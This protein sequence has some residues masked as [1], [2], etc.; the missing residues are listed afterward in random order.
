[1]MTAHQEERLWTQGGT[2]AGATWNR[3]AMNDRPPDFEHNELHN[4]VTTLRSHKWVIAAVAALVLGTIMVRSYLETPSYRSEARLIV[5]QSGAIFNMQTE[6]QLLASA[7]VAEVSAEILE[8]EDDPSS[9][10]DGLGV[11]VSPQTEILTINYVSSDPEVARSR[12]Q[13]FA[14]GYV[15]YKREQ[16]QAEVETSS[17]RLFT[18]I[19][20]L[21]ERINS[22]TDE[23]G[24]TIDAGRRANLQT[25][26][27]ALVSQ[28]ALLE[29][30]RTTSA[31]SAT[32]AIGEVIQPASLPSAPFT[33]NYRQNAILGLFLGLLLGMLAALLRERL[34]DRLRGRH[35]FE[36]RL[37]HPVLAV[38]P[39][40]P[41][42]RRRGEAKVVALEAPHS[43]ASESYKTLRTSTLFIASNRGTRVLLI[44]G[45]HAGEGKT[46]TLANL[47][48]SLAHADRRV[49][50]VSADLRKP[51]LH[52]F[53]RIDNDKGVT[54][55]L[56]G[57]TTLP[58]SLIRVGVDRLR[59]LPSGPSPLNPA[60]VLG[61]EAMGELLDQLRDMADLVLLDA[62]PILSV[63]DA[64]VLS[65][66]SDGVI[67]VVNPSQSSR[68]AVV[69]AVQR[70]EQVGT[71]IVGG[72][73]NNF[74][75]SEGSGSYYGWRYAGESSPGSEKASRFRLR[76][77][78]RS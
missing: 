17:E 18:Q 27:N 71:H 41:N 60:E 39:R 23:L 61:S 1:M 16:K 37:G 2:G 7:P 45:P 15:M 13:A 11:L 68:S 36:A 77:Q 14:D 38:I 3:P 78:A 67:L 76:R 54:T 28:L 58:E 66:M 43:F 44:T 35:D 4:Y 75:L 34:D 31:A 40:I 48:V 46:T 42:W 26:I 65:P 62:P 21:N 29:Q 72:V 20:A 22:L 51:R 8:F 56:S 74:D 64:T 10:L 73:L 59:V 49:I 32:V 69:N 50:V 33:P 25:Q 6:S 47:G 12:A 53:F 70:L 30:E 9:L 57:E 19:G 5:Q 24:E 55:I 63:A 52:E